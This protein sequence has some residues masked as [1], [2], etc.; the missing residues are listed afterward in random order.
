MHRRMQVLRLA[1]VPAVLFLLLS[2][3][4]TFLA[5]AAAAACVGG[6]PVVTPCPSA[7]AAAQA[8][9]GNSAQLPVSNAAFSGACTPGGVEGMLL[10]SSFGCHHLN[11]T[12][13]LGAVVLSNGD[14]RIGAITSNTALQRTQAQ[15]TGIG[16]DPDLQALSTAAGYSQAL[17]DEVLLQFDVTPTASGNLAFQYV[18]G[19]EE[20]PDFAPSPDYPDPSPYNDIFGF[21]MWEASGTHTNI[22]LLPNASSPVSISTVNALHNTYYI[23]NDYA[24]ATTATEL[25]GLTKLIK[26]ADYYVTA[27]TTYHVKLAIADGQDAGIDSIV[28]IRAGSVR[29]NIKDCVGAWVPHTWGPLNGTC[30]GACEGGDGLLPEVYFISVAAANGGNECPTVNGTTRLSIPC[31]NNNPCPV[32]CT[33]AWVEAGNCT[34]QCSGGSGFVPEVFLM[35]S[36]AMYGGSCPSTNGTTRLSLPC[37]NTT[38]CPPRDCVGGWVAAAEGA[39]QASCGGGSGLLL[40]RYVINV[41][42]CV[43]R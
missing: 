32:N 14:A 28:W 41:D 33:A 18:F 22:A 30:T 25:N 9:T 2:T 13:P 19:S 31:K 16:S 34:G 6:D 21:F 4:V 39:C 11:S 43:Q 3:S 1:Q 8:L 42:G 10:I 5:P 26:T 7:L 35:S 40:E 36:P 15:G 12:M 27:G 37:N 20:Y 38:P 29:F 23:N 17:Y 24:S